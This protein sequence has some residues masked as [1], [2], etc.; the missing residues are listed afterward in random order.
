MACVCITWLHIL[1]VDT[2]MGDQEKSSNRGIVRVDPSTKRITE[3]VEKPEASDSRLA[4]IVFYIF[5]KETLP[6]LK[7]F[8]DKVCQIAKHPPTPLAC[9]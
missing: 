5:R 8:L 9:D 1:L 4:S 2:E 6:V 3:F 7:D